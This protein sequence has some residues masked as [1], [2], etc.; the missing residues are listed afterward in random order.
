MRLF[1]LLFVGLIALPVVFMFAFERGLLDDYIDE[2]IIP[3]GPFI[4]AEL[5][6][7]VTPQDLDMAINRAL[8]SNAYEDALMY[9]EIAAY[10]SIPLSD[11]T[12]T[13][14]EEA[15]TL[16]LRIARDTGS[17]FEGFLTGAGS[18]TAG[19][20][21]AIASDLTV[22]GDVRDIGREGAKLVSGEE[23]SELILGL[24]V[25]GVAATAA[26][27]ATGGGALPVK[28]GVS[29]MKVAKRTGTLTRAFAREL[30]NIV[31]AAVNFPASQNPQHSQPDQQCRHQTVSHNLRLKGRLQPPHPPAGRYEQAST[32]RWPCR[33]RAPTLTRRDWQ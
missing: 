31:R 22:V 16:L 24:S 12:R 13:R 18:D 19:F 23:Y 3:A 7:T 27:V 1:N 4:Q 33:K 2:S 8:D 29:L 28:I 30:R 32:Q 15:G 17:F 26:T 9:A 20:A 5:A 11:A 6:A 21:G 25:V 10:A 14:I